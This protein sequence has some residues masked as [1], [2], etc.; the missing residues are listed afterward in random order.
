MKYTT[1][2]DCISPIEEI[3]ALKAAGY[4]VLLDGKVYQIPKGSK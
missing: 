4:K 1:H 3:K 2:E